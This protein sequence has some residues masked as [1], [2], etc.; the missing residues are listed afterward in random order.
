MQGEIRIPVPEVPENC[1]QCNFSRINEDSFRC[2][3]LNRF[4]D[5]WL[6]KNERPPSCPIQALSKSVM[7]R[8]AI[9]NGGE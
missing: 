4:V 7:R 3:I 9:Q 6:I 2:R 5:S 1:G 8:E